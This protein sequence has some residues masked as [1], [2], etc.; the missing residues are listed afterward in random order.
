MNVII[1]GASKGIGKAIA[2]RFAKGGFDV[3]IC[4]RNEIELLEAKA[5]ISQCNNAIK[6]YAQKCDM[7]DVHDVKKFAK[8]MLIQMNKVDIL[9]H[10][11]GRFLPGDITNEEDG[12]LETLVETNLYSAYHLTRAIVPSMMGNE[13]DEHGSRGHVFTIC[14]VAGLQAYAHGGSYSISKF[15]LVGFTKNLRLEMMPYHI[16]VTAVHPGATMSDSWLGSGVDE[17]RIMKAEDVAESVWSI[18]QLSPQAVVEEIL[19][20]PMLG[21]L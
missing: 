1:T 19:L 16:K 14:S 9:I 2:M 8:S 17:H 20:R 3:G 13:I 18:S 4:A 10:N 5:D 11:A 12:L 21:D 7:C 6:V 15:A